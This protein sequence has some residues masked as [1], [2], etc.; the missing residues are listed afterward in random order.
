MAFERVTL[1]ANGVEAEVV[2]ARGALLCRL[3]VGGREVL[4]LDQATLEDPTKNV[5]GGV[6]LLFPF[7]GRLEGDRFEPASTTMPQHGFGRS[8]AWKVV[9]QRADLVRMA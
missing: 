6:P 2:P 7:A 1:R 4:Y 9:E 8:L 3:A 5:R